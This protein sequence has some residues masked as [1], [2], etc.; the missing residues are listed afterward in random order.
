MC[1]KKRKERTSPYSSPLD[2]P[3]PEG[4]VLPVQLSSPRYSIYGRQPNEKRELETTS[5]IAELGSRGW[6]E[7]T[8]RYSTYASDPYQIH[9]DITL[10]RNNIVSFFFHF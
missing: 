7:S 9:N 2:Q 6:K 3:I 10:F 8:K 4:L 5:T 1:F